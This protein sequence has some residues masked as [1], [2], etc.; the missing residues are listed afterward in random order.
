MPTMESP[1]QPSSPPILN[2]IG[3]QVALGPPRRDLLAVY[4][5]W[6]N[7]FEVTRTLAIGMRPTSWESEDAWYQRIC[8]SERDAFFTIYERSSLH[9]IGG[10]GLHNIDHHNRTAEFGILIGEKNYW[11]RGYGTETTALMQDF[12]FTALGL[13]NIMLRVY[14]FNERGLRAY[15]RAG[16]RVSGR[17]RESHRVGGRAYDEIYMDSL[18]AEFQS[19]VLHRLLP[20]G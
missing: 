16:F 9:P 10:T 14:S 6:V 7:D 18:A 8:S 15:L 20:D 12:G 5:K 13:H 11:G 3:T 19:P 1:Q 4:L 2:I 17:R